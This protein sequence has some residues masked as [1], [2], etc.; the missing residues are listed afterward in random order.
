MDIKELTIDHF[1]RVRQLLAMCIEELTVEQLMQQ[2][3][4][5]S[6]P[7]GWTGW[8]L[9]RTQDHEISGLA[10]RE[11]AWIVDGWHERFGMPADP[12]NTGTGHSMDEVRAFQSPG[13]SVILDYHDAVYAR[14][15]EYIQTITPEELDRVLNEPRW[16]PMP[17][18]GV[19]LVSVM[20]DNSMHTGEMAYL[21]GLLERRR[22]YPA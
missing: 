11:Q 18:V 22:W 7:L 2:P 12:Q 15:Q 19:R 10:N 6:N 1:G 9:T 3:D 13:A 16:N 8:H 21:K 14:T 20:H 17:T 4:S 5:A